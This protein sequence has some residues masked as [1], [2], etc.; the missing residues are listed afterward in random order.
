MSLIITFMFEPAKLQMNCAR[1][2][3]AMNARGE[4][5]Q[6]AVAGLSCGVALTQPSARSWAALD[7]AAL[8]VTGRQGS[9]PNHR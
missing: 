6:L 3:G 9:V 2:R 5:A 1:A 7:V 4:P 8:V